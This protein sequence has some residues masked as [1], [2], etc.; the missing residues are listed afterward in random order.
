MKE[1]IVKRV[2]YTANVGRYDRVMQPHIVNPNFD[3]VLFTNDQDIK[4]ERIGVWQIRK[5]SYVNEDNTRIARWVKTHPH[6]LLPEYDYSIWI[7]SNVNIESS[8]AYALFDKFFSMSVPVSCFV[9]LNRDCIYD[10]GLQVGIY[11]REDFSSIIPQM[12]FLK[13]EGYPR[14]Y[15]LSETNCVYRNHHIN[16]VNKLN[17]EWWNMI[18]R[19]SR[20]DQLSFCYVLWKNGIESP[21]LLGDKHNSRNHPYFKYSLHASM[22]T[23]DWTPSRI[24]MR[25]LSF[26]YNRMINAASQSIGEKFWALTM[27]SMNSVFRAFNLIPK[28]RK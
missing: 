28:L 3:Y 13:K 16:K 12:L 2:L 11:N 23:L 5:I 20:R 14:H 9:H 1:N 10:E 4:E 17:E 22:Q 21:Y 7:D 26:A 18:C 24:V 8:E 19:F 15:G 27:Y 6:I 25:M